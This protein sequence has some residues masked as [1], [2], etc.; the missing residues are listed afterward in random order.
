MS[1][2]T[3]SAAQLIQKLLVQ[4]SMGLEPPSTPWP[5]YFGRMPDGH[6]V[7][8]QLVVVYDTEP[9][10]DGRLMG[11]GECIEHPGFQVRVRVSD[12]NTG[13]AKLA[14]IAAVLDQVKNNVVT[15]DSAATYTIKAVT[16]RGGPIPIG[17]DERGREHFTLNAT[18]TIVENP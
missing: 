18:T 6:N 10:Q 2:L 4:E 15:G 17:P 7:E 16:R 9:V 1:I 13:H 5:I 11:T 8:D 14:A 12:Y 3:D